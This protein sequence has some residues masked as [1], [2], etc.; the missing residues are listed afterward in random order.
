MDASTDHQVRNLQY[1]K[2]TYTGFRL[3]R[4]RLQQADFIAL[5][6][7]IDC[8]IKKFGHTHLKRA[9]SFARCKQE[10]MYLMSGYHADTPITIKAEAIHKADSRP[11]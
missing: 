2:Q 3:Q 6:S 9:V 4:V 1:I 8:N 10:Q 5:K 11:N 7:F